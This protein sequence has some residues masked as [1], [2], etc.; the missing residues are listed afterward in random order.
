[1]E[2]QT[3]EDDG[4]MLRE[5]DV[6][7]EEDCEITLLYNHVRFIVVLKRSRSESAG[8]Q[9]SIEE[10]MLKELDKSA[11]NPDPFV[12]DRC[13]EDIQELAISKSKDLVY[14]LA[15]GRSGERNGNITLEEWLSPKTFVLQLRTVRGELRVEQL[16]GIKEATYNHENVYLSP[17]TISFD[18]KEIQSVS[19]KDIEVI[20]DLNFEKFSKVS[21][22]GVCYAF[23]FASK[24]NEKQLVRE[25]RALRDLSKIESPKKN[26]PHIPRLHAIVESGRGVVGILED[27]IDS[28]GNLFDYICDSGDMIADSV[29]E[30]T[31]ED[32]DRWMRQIEEGIQFLH[33]HGIVWGD[34]KAENVLI[35]K[36]RNAWLI[37]FGGSWTQ[38]WVDRQLNEMKEGDLQGLE[39]IRNY[40]NGIE[41]ELNDAEDEL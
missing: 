36:E 20:E 17:K 37:D 34:A 9:V 8:D 7:I 31:D 5:V 2:P 38:G 21:W 26:S 19:A 28:S 29:T 30:I 35:D 33:Q 15:S 10:I 11:K 12:Y 6:G 39:R 16:S 18:K 40:L 13:L 4:I 23:K 14:K 24:G 22:R 27:Y 1:M 32:R 3:T 25:M 41:E